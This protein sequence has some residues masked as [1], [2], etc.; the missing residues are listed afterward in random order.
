MSAFRIKNTKYNSYKLNNKIKSTI[1]I[2]HKEK[3]NDIEKKE[4]NYNKLNDKIN[5]Y[6]KDIYNIDKREIITNEDIE[7]KAILRDKIDELN[8]KI[9][10]L[11]YQ[12][13]KMDYF[14]ENID[15]LKEYYNEDKEIQQSNDIKDLNDLFKLKKD[16]IISNNKDNLYDTYMKRVYKHNE[17]KK[18]NNIIK[19][20]ENCKIE[21]TI[22][23]NEGL[24]IC[25]NCGHSENAL[26]DIEKSCV[27][28]R[29]TE[30]KPSM[31]KRIN[32]LS[33]L[34]NQFQAKESTDIDDEVYIQIKEELRRQ[35]KVDYSKLNYDLM[36]Q[37][38]KKLRLNKFYEH[39]YHII[40]KLNGLP[41]PSLSKKLEYMIKQKFIEIQQP[42]L[43]FKKS[44]RKNFTTYNTMINKILQLLNENELRKH[45]PILKNRDKI[46]DFDYIWYKICQYNGYKYIPT[47]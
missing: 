25:K 30:N 41:P 14:Y 27:K 39:I 40:N 34:L 5:K 26:L 45:F 11:N 43:L 17:R 31:Y 36:R 38:L 29:N 15:L 47:I 18:H 10:I 20:C 9:D 46:N 23:I 7:K 8:Y 44:N 13:D 35:R 28:D 12:N 21:K 32:H 6:N 33:E 16:N 19:L 24:L 2:K 42:Y 4:L 3:L 37:V 22:H 1:D